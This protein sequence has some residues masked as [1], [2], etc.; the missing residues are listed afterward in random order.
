MN[1]CFSARP[2]E[3]VEGFERLVPASAGRLRPWGLVCLALLSLTPIGLAQGEP[4]HRSFPAQA[5]R[6][7]LILGVAPDAALNGKSDRLAPGARIRGTNNM[8]LIPAAAIGQ[9]LTVHYTR[10]GTTGL[11][12][13]IWVLNEVERAR[14]PWPRTDREVQT[15]AFDP[16]AQTWKKP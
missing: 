16:A 7:E 13:D 9:R 4:G 5:L 12:M 14:Q 11:L 1:R 3:R 6:G 8:L 15:W 10:E 2:V